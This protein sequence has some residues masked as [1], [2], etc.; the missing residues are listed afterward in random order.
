M[1]FQTFS[2][3]DRPE[4][5]LRDVAYMVNGAQEMLHILC[6]VLEPISDE[7]LE[8]EGAMALQQHRHALGN[9]INQILGFS[10]LVMQRERAEFESALIADL[11]RILTL[12]RMCKSRMQHTPAPVSH[13]TTLNLP[14]SMDTRIWPAAPRELHGV[15]AVVD[16]S[17]VN[18]E[19]FT[20]L[21]QQMHLEV[22]AFADGRQ[23]LSFLEGNVVDL[24]LLDVIM[25]G[26]SG[27]DV[28]TAL[29]AQPRWRHVQVLMLS[30]LDDLEIVAQC[31]ESGADDY[32]VKDAD[33]VLFRARVQSSLQRRKLHLVELE[34]YFSPS[35]ARQMLI[36][37]DL[38]LEGREANITVL[39][40]DIRGFSRLAS[41]MEPGKVVSWVNATMEALADCVLQHKGVVVD[42]I[43]DEMLAMW[44][45]PEEQPDHAAR[46]C[47]AALDMMR[48]LPKLNDR[49]EAEIGGPMAYGIGL[50]SGLARVGNVG[51]R[52]R[53]KY[54]P[55][56]NTVN[57][58]SRVQGATKYV[59]ADILLTRSTH[60]QIQD[61][62]ATR[63]L[64]KVRVVNI[65]EPV[66]L[67]ELAQPGEP[68]WEDRKTLYEEGLRLFEKGELERAAL[69]AGRL[70]QQT[71][72][73]GPNLS[74][75]SRTMACLVDPS[76]WNAVW[77]LPGK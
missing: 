77:D 24:V 21:L 35:V 11:D 36:K 29:R 28:L 56:G 14:A 6:Q 62:F 26:M 66:E 46:A 70:I 69:V 1:V 59:K 61:H 8:R 44:G 54:G 43:G 67:Y 68:D 33:S 41:R 19:L 65:A 15:V 39:F 13:H 16:D 20:R 48:T 27:L 49:W 25:P 74:L 32:V 72:I 3:M 34:R 51:T 5:Y 50:N 75:M 45:A 71:G 22:H 73:K 42:F 2:R 47:Q 30:A 38:I 10:Q 55:L 40:C 9:C 57:L 60:T 12:C 53:F 37:P 63:R 76:R 64:A 52:K 7:I 17:E 23:A 31:L 58:G 4:S 18:R